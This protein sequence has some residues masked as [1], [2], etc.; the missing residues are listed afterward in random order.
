MDA[1]IDDLKL[2]LWLRQRDQKVW[3]TKDGKKIPI[4][5]MTTNHIVNAIQYFERKEELL[6]AIGGFDP[7]WDLD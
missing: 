5:D 2:E 3:T 1:T 4:K 6:D 7:D